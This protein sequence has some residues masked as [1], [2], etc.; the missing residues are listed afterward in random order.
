MAF[1][2]DEINARRIRL[3]TARMDVLCFDCQR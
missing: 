3:P 1:K 2:E